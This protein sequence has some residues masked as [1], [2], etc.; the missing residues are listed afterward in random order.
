M[1][2]GTGKKEVRATFEGAGLVG[3][4]GNKEKW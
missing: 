1:T 2:P 3:N 4:M